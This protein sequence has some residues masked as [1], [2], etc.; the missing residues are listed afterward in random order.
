MGQPVHQPIRERLCALRAEG[1]TFEQIAQ[2]TGLSFWT[3]RNLVRRHGKQGGPA[4]APD[5]TRCGAGG[6]LRVGQFFFR[7]SRWLK[8]LHPSWGAP[9]IRMKLAQRYVGAS[10]P[11][12]RQMQ[13]WFRHNGLNEP[14]QRKG[15]SKAERA[16]STHECW[17]VDAKE[18]LTL[19]GGQQCSYLSVV[20]EHSGSSLGAVLF[21]LSPNQSSHR[22]TSV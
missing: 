3:V 22:A 19:A 18:R 13:R 16:K 17:Q 14:R 21:P 5:Y 6:H 7:V 15:E 11:S 1:Q 20:D 4:P 8:R 10:L 2:E 9:F 12:S